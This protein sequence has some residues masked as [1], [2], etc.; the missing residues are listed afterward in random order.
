MPRFRLCFWESR[1]WT[2][3]AG[4]LISDSKFT[5]NACSTGQKILAIPLTINIPLDLQP[6]FT[7]TLVNWPWLLR[8][9]LPCVP[10]G[11]TP[12][13]TLVVVVDVTIRFDVWGNAELFDR[14]GSV[15]LTRPWSLVRNST[16]PWIHLCRSNIV[17]VASETE[18]CHPLP[19]G[20]GHGVWWKTLYVPQ[21]VIG[22]V[23]KLLRRISAQQLACGPPSSNWARWRAGI[24]GISPLAPPRWSSFDLA[25]FDTHTSTHHGEID[26]NST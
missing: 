25:L 8:S 2:Q 21:L 3:T 15:L 5:E 7:G 26:R 17:R 16:L 1:I 22:L 23:T 12:R 13:F 14:R 19:I 10:E 9:L 20:R 18:L 24:V 6:D 11:P 4:V